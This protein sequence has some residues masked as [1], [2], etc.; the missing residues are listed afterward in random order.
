MSALGLLACVAIAGLPFAVA[1]DWPVL[2]VGGVAGA[3]CAA[4][5]LLRSLGLA[6]AGGVVALIA[7]AVALLLSD[8]R[9][10][11]VA[12]LA[13]GAALYLVLD[14]TH[15]RQRFARA[16]AVR[17]VAQA[18]IANV[19]ASIGLAFTAAALLAAVATV[20]RG[21]PSALLRPVLAGAGV[22]LVALAVLYAARERPENGRA[23][24]KGRAP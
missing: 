14:A 20:L 4:A 22:V 17:E 1:P 3:I 12:A 19:A 6:L 16:V 13:M 21:G 23:N 9:G 7:F 18:H 8:A 24:V 15:E 2:A 11:G 5:F 10:A